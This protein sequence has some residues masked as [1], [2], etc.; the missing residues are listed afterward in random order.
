MYIYSRVSFIY[1]NITSFEVCTDIGSH[2][3]LAQKLAINK[4]NPQFFPNQT[5]ILAILSTLTEFH[6]CV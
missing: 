3:G 1:K 6:N 2:S 4:K 5:D